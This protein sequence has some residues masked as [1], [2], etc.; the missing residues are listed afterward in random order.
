MFQTF[1]FLNIQIL[2]QILQTFY[3]SKF[4]NFKVQVFN[5][6][7]LQIKQFGCLNLPQ[8]DTYYYNYR[9]IKFPSIIHFIRPYDFNSPPCKFPTK[10]Y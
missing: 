5:F 7:N 10:F 4:F 2:L 9:L 6:S 1:K 3:V 8:Q